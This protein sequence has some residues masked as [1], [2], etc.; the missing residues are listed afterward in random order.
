MVLCVSI[1]LVAVIF[2]RLHMYR[3]F[4]SKGV[5]LGGVGGGAQSASALVSGCLCQQENTCN[6]CVDVSNHAVDL[7]LDFPRC[8]KCLQLSRCLEEP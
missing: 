7:S 8:W 3:F 4:Y 2:I 5:S 6:V 1:R